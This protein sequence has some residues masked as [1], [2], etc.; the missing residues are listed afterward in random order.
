MNRT[1]VTGCR[2]RA[3][4]ELM[5]V[6]FAEHHRARC[7]ESS[8]DLGVI[9]RDAIRKLPASACRPTPAV[10]NKSLRPTGIHA[11]VRANRPS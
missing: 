4:S 2:C 5:Q 11:A 8:N 7:L 3:Y 1:E 9:G 6:L 10:S